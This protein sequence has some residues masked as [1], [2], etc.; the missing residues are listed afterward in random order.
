MCGFATQF[1]GVNLVW[2]VAYGADNLIYG[3]DYTPASAS[4]P[5]PGPRP[6]PRA[7]A[8]AMPIPAPGPTGGTTPTLPEP[9]SS[10]VPRSREEGCELYPNLC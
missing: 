6:G 7:G 5:G 4:A 9:G 8:G 2:Q 3:L 10:P 1:A